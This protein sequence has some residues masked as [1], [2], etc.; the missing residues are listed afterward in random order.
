M[1]NRDEPI[2]PASEAYPN[3]FRRKIMRQVV[4]YM[5]KNG[6]LAW[7]KP[8]QYAATYGCSVNEVE[9]E[10]LRHLPEGCDK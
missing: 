2:K 5:A 7:I 8:A 4:A 1:A 3:D 10:I 9:A 6:D